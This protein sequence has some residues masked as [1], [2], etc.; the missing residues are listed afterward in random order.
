MRR[1]AYRYIIIGVVTLLMAGC[2]TKNNTSKSRF[3][4][5]FT[6]RYNT[7]FNG[8][9]AFIDGTQEK[10]KG[11]K[12][13]FTEMIPLYAVG[14]KQSRTIGKSQFDRAIEK[15]EKTIKLHSI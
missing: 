1:I 10:D 13:N 15:M 4:H 8:S 3:W 5:S 6:A 11:N 12:D 9:Q 7:Y 2:S 14:N